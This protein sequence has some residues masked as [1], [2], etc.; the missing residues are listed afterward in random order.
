MSIDRLALLNETLD[1][2]EAYPATRA[3]VDNVYPDLQLGTVLRDDSIADWPRLVLVRRTAP[4]ALGYGE[5]L[6]EGLPQ[7]DGSGN[8]LQQWVITPADLPSLKQTARTR[9]NT[10]AGEKITTVELARGLIAGA[11]RPRTLNIMAKLDDVLQ[12]INDAATPEAVRVILD[13]IEEA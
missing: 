13:E 10:V 2:I 6:G 9:A 8:W 7:P 4:P 5:V 11:P 3:D 1:A 12:R